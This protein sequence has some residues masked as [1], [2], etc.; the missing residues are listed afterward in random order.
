MVRRL[1]L[2]AGKRL[3]LTFR[4]VGREFVAIGLI[5]EFVSVDLDRLSIHAPHTADID[6][7]GLNLPVGRCH[8]IAHGADAVTVL[9][10]YGRALQRVA[11]IRD[12]GDRDLECRR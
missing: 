2:Y 7:K 6:T 3:D 9:V 5:T 12:P 1:R 10:T 8:D 11:G 4:E